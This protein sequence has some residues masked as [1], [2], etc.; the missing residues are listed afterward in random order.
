VA[1]LVLPSVATVDAAGRRIR[2]W[3]VETPVV[4]S[5]ELGDAVLLKLENLQTTGSFKVRGALAAMTGRDDHHPVVAAS[6]GNHALGIAYAARLAR[7][8]ATVVVPASASSAKIAWL[9]ASGVELVEQGSSYDESEAFALELARATGARYVSP[10]N[11]A[12]VIS[13]Q[14]TVAVELLSQVSGP[15]TI[16]CPVGGGGLVSGVGLWAKQREGVTLVG[17]ES[18]AS[19]ALSVSVAAG[20]LMRVECTS[21]L[22]DGLTGNLESGSITFPLAAGLVD[23]FVAVSDQEIRRAIRFLALEHGQIVEGSGAVTVAAIL[24]GKITLESGCPTV[25]IVS[26]RNIGQ[27]TVNRI[28]PRPARTAILSE[29]K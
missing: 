1:E 25:A 29:P 3:I 14:G 19:R 6:A 23:R 24:S 17:V 4:P 7:I 12:D 16:L 28:L 22:A 5:P 18:S 21:T 9:R 11:D 26:G 2:S 20:K 13:G 10:Y 27:A 15:M 8:E